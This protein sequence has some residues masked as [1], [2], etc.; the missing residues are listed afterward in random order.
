MVAKTK[1]NAKGVIP[2]YSPI[3]I[4]NSEGELTGPS[5]E[6]KDE[7]LLEIYKYMILGRTFDQR[8]LSLQR[9]GRIGTYAPISGQEAVQVVSAMCLKEDD[10]MFPTYR[11]YAAMYV[12]G[13]PMR[14]LFLFPMGH[15]QGGRAPQNVNIYAISIS[16]ATHLPHAVGAAWA[17]KIK[18]E[19][20]AFITYHGDGATSEGDF[21]EAMNFAGVFQVP[22]V[23]ICENNGWAISLPRDHQT[24]SETIAQKGEAY[25][26][27]SF[28]VDG[29][30]PL[31]V[32]KVVTEGLER[33]RAGEGPTFIEAVTYRLGPHTTADDPGRYRSQEEL[34]QMKQR[35]PLVRTSLYL[36]KL[37]LLSEAEEAAMWEEAKTVVG[38]ALKA[39]ESIAPPEPDFFFHH[40]YEEPTPNILKQ[41]REFVAE[42]AE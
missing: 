18:G 6:I 2:R 25:G 11:D 36:R 38:E 28:M 41:M 31:A 3:Q 22:L 29:N 19:S 32:Y 4:L 1:S 8:A 17:S 40:V 16:I 42:E 35:D 37:N 9:Q 20:K 33:A 7:L 12:H 30:D 5:P 13:M 34:D 15:P 23:T 24:H 14:D 39:A 26:I 27:P 21:H 10:W